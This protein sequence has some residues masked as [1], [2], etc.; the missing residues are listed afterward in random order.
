MDLLTICVVLLVIPFLVNVVALGLNVQRV[1]KTL[2]LEPA[3]DAKPRRIYHYLRSRS[4]LTVVAS[5]TYLA[6]MLGF[7]FYGGFARLD[8]LVQ[9]W[10]LPPVLAGLTYIGILMLARRLLVLTPFLAYA[11]FVIE[12]R[13]G[14]NR[15]N[16]KTFVLD[17]LKRRL[18]DGLSFGLAAIGAM[19]LFGQFGPSAWPWLWITLV[20]IQWRS[21]A[22]G[23]PLLHRFSPLPAGS[24]RTAIDTLCRRIGFPLAGVF[25]ID[26]SRRTAG[27]EAMCIGL[28]RNRRV[29]VS[30]TLLQRYP[31]SEITAIVA[32]EVAHIR[33]H[34]MAFRLVALAALYLLPCWLISQLMTDES[35]FC[36]FGFVQPS[37]PAALV[38]ML[39]YFGAWE[40]LLTVPI[41]WMLRQHEYQADAFAAR[42]V[43]DP[44]I[45][46]Q[47]LGRIAAD[48]L[49][50]RNQH[51]L[52]TALHRVH[53]TIAQRVAAL[54]QL[55]I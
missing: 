17:L 29:V 10:G 31:V 6:A 43:G 8:V 25:V 1:G 26:S 11:Q 39:M 13:F 48:N 32:H 16:V 50:A 27:S 18:A 19:V 9:S 44:E 41:K 49:I 2:N 30:D 45:V 15:M 37:L 5:A 47:M 23:Y 38:L 54:Y 20:V 35:V 3:G 21:T 14:F 40:P 34:H 46:V 36:V 7:W 51:P 53:P 52:Y 4:L 24:V 12:Q 28:G 55:K 33:C 22:L 42:A